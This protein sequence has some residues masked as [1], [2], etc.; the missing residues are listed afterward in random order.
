MDN[1]CRGTDAVSRCSRQD[2]L[3]EIPSTDTPH[4]NCGVCADDPN[5]TSGGP[6]A[7]TI[8]Y[9]L[10]RI[11]CYLLLDT[12]MDFAV[13]SC[14]TAVLRNGYSSYRIPRVR[15]WD[16]IVS[17][18]SWLHVNHIWISSCGPGQKLSSVWGLFIRLIHLCVPDSAI[19]HYLYS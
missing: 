2:L 10:F 6:I 1:V 3:G 14:G 9:L 18:G 19:E 5:D 11:R 15:H 17:T 7:R 8:V 12:E 4:Y 16:S 13:D